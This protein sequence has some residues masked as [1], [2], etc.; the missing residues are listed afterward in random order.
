MHLPMLLTH[1]NL[2]SLCRLTWAI[3]FCYLKLFCMSKGHLPSSF[4]RLFDGSSIDL[5]AIM[6]YGDALISLYHTIVTFN[7]PFENIVGKEENADYQHFLLFQKCFLF[8]LE[9]I[10]LFGSPFIC[11]LQMFSMTGLKCCLLLNS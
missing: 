9:Q 10:L 4:S 6:H 5:L 3:T 2:H 11:H 8:Y 7:D 1:I